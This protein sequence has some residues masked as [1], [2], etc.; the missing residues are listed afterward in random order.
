MS[1]GTVKLI[2]RS[3][4]ASKSALLISLIPAW[5]L[6]AITIGWTCEALD[7]SHDRIRIASRAEASVI[8][9]TTSTTLT[10]DSKLGKL[11]SIFRGKSMTVISNAWRNSSSNCTKAEPSVISGEL[12]GASA[13][14]MAR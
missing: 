11:I 5:T 6:L 3:I 2:L 13:D 12:I 4:D 8:S 1:Y 14:K 10:S 7:L 9:V